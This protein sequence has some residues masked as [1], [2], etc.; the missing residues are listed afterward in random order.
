MASGAHRGPATLGG[1]IPRT[2]VVRPGACR[3]TQVPRPSLR[4]PTRQRF[5]AGVI[6]VPIC[7]PPPRL[8]HVPPSPGP[9][10]PRVKVLV[11]ATAPARVEAASTSTPMSPPS[12]PRALRRRIRIPCSKRPPLHIDAAGVVAGP[13][14]TPP[15]HL[16]RQ[17]RIARPR[18]PWRRWG[19]LLRPRICTCRE[20]D[21][22]VPF[23]PRR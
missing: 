12:V 21:K 15:I 10:P 23:D 3:R 4:L 5:S 18:R 22:L 16:R 1:H 13:T 8:R 11:D 7:L 14:Q 6:G 20:S 9:P 2:Q 19:G 17:A